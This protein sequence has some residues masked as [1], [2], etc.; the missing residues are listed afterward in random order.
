M[1]PLALILPMAL[2][3]QDPERTSFAVLAGFDFEPGMELPK[4]VQALDEKL[5]HLSG[6]MMRETPGSG[7]VNQFMLINDA[8]GCTGTPKLNEIVFCALPEGVT[9]E[10]RTGVVSVIGTI[11]VGEQQEDGETVALYVMDADKVQ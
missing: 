8:C 4:E 5:V 6:F 7:P 1:K 10:M 9:I 3:C 2:L 11:Y